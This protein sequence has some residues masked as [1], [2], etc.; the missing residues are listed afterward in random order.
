MN[1]K[2]LL[3]LSALSVVASVASA[4]SLVTLYGTVDV[5]GRYVKTD[6]QARRL[7][8]NSSGLNSGQLGFKGEED[9]GGGL[10]AGFILESDIFTDTGTTDSVRNKFFNRRSLVRLWGNWGELRLGRDYTPSY[11][12][13][14]I[15][16]AFGNLGLGNMLNIHQMYNGTRID[17]SIGYVLPAGLGGFYGDA[18]VAA[19]EGGTT[20]DRPG[21]YTGARGGYAAGPINVAIAAGQQRFAV[22]FPG[23]SGVPNAPVLSNGL[24]VPAPI[25]S[26][27]K[28]Y[29]IGASYDFGV[30]KLIGFYDREVLL[31]ARENLYSIS[32]A[33]PLGQGEIHVSYDRSNLNG[34][35]N[36]T[37]VSDGVSTAIDQVALG[38]LY[39]LSKRTALYTA[40]SRIDNKN[41][42]TAT[43]PSSAGKAT[44]GGKS[45]G[46][47]FGIRHFF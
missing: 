23:L 33:V 5:N 35:L 4:Q 39:N 21:R 27:Q 6:G 43:L 29:N 28:T 46:A 2:R 42:T 44:P 15:F 17:N 31:A 16:D 9:L 13:H 19:G 12:S 32:A 22:A 37:G 18:K 14:G 38:Y 34:H 3:V 24:P 7:S 10:K 1:K 26:T 36:A 41:G 30:V 47:E 45:Q 8:E 11:W 40:I 25:G 20:F